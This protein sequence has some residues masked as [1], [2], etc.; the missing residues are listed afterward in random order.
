MMAL[1]ANNFVDSLR[2]E[3]WILSY[4]GHHFLHVRLLKIRDGAVASSLLQVRILTFIRELGWLHF[5]VT[6][7]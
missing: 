3:L 4:L 7:N 5:F 1:N 6:Q 2:I